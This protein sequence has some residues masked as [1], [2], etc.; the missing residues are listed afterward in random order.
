MKPAV[1]LDRDGTLNRD[2]GYLSDPEQL[3]LYPGAGQ[4]VARFNRAG[5]LVIIISNQSGIG[6]GLFSEADLHNVTQRLYELLARDGGHVD[7]Q[8][9][10]PYHDEAEDPRYRERPEWRK[11]QPGMIFHAAQEHRIDMRKSLLIGD[12]E[13]DILAGKR[14]RLRTC[15]VLTG[16]GAFAY[17][18]LKD[19]PQ[20]PDFVFPDLLAAAHYFCPATQSGTLF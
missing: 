16:E 17:E 9:Y 2:P 12:R 1:F 13:S 14:A 7:A 15:M 5:Y 8:Y 6:R 19:T 11:P 3:E 10:A 20:A 18:R 4:A